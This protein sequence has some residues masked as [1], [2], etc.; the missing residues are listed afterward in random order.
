M[1][2]LDPLRHNYIYMYLYIFTVV[3]RV[4]RVHPFWKIDEDNMK[5]V[6]YFEALLDQ[7]TATAVCYCLARLCARPSSVVPGRRCAVHFSLQRAVGAEEPTAYRMSGANGQRSE[8][9]GVLAHR[10]RVSWQVVHGVFLLW[11]KHGISCCDGGC[12]QF[13]NGWLSYATSH[14]RLRG[15]LQDWERKKGEAGDAWNTGKGQHWRSSLFKP[16]VTRPRKALHCA[17]NNIFGKDEMIW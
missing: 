8:Q 7:I 1:I 3:F 16:F 11:N 14:D 6:D 15:G 12:C 13:W 9:K 5:I 4:F 17:P 10:K 2:Q